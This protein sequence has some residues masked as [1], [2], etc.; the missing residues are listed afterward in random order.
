MITH[1]HSRAL[2][3]LAHSRP[4]STAPPPR[5]RRLASVLVLSSALTTSALGYTFYADA[6]ST[7]P[8]SSDTRALSDLARAYVTYGLCSIPAL[9]DAAP[10]IMGVLFSIPGVS[11][12]AQGFVRATFFH[13]VHILYSSL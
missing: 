9:V 7:T 13:Q 11:N 5:L 8:S 12:I 3:L 4:L 2:R 6:S 10:S 1:I